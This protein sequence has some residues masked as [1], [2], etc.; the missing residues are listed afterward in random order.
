MFSSDK[1][2]KLNLSVDTNID[3]QYLLTK[4]NS[5]LEKINLRYVRQN[6]YYI[7]YIDNPSE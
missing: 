7:Q 5:L 2:K 6:G 3:I 4:D 1:Y